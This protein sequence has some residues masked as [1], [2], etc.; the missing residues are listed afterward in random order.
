MENPIHRFQSARRLALALPLAATLALAGGLKA[1]TVTETFDSAESTAAN[2]WTASGNEANGN[3]FGWSNSNEA[4]GTAG[5]AGGFFARSTAYGSY[6]DTSGG[7]LSRTHTLN[8]S[9][10]FRLRNGY[11][12]EG[13][14]YIGF[15]DPASLV[16][17]QAPAN[18]VG[19]SFAEPEADPEDPFL[20]TALVIGNGGSDSGVI[21]LPQDTTLAFNLTWTGS[22]DG[23]GTLTGTLAGTDIGT[24]N[25]AAGSAN[26]T[27]F[28]LLGG[29]N[30]YDLSYLTTEAYF[31]NLT[32]TKV[33]PASYTITYNGN[34]NDG[35]TAPDP[36]TKIENQPLTL[37]SNSGGMAKSGLVFAGWNTAADG[38]GTLYTEGETYSANGDVTLYARWVTAYT[39]T[40]NG[41]NNDSGTAPDPQTKLEIQPLPLAIN[42]GN[43]EKIGVTFAGWNTAA[44]GSGTPYAEGETYTTNANVTL[45]AR[46]GRITAAPGN[47]NDPAT[48]VDG[49]TLGVPQAGSNV[50]LNHAVTLSETT[51]E[52]ESFTNNATLTFNGWNTRLRAATVT[53][54]GTITHPNQTDV[55]GTSGV[56][57]DWTPDHRVWIVCTNLTVNASQSIDVNGKGYQ[58]GQG[59]HPRVGRGSGGGG[60]Y[61]TNTSGGGGTHGGGGGLTGRASIYGS[62]T[63]PGDPGSGGGGNNWGNGGNGGGAVRIE[64]AGKVTLNGSITADGNGP[65]HN[66]AGGGSGGAVF[67]TCNAVAGGGTLSANGAAINGEN[68]QGGAGA[69]G[70]I[71]LAY[72]TAA[73]AVQ[74]ATQTPTLTIR[75]R[76]GGRGQSYS[77]AHGEPGTLH[78]SDASFFPGAA[79]QGGVLH[80]AGVTALTLPSLAISGGMFGVAEGTSLTVQGNV[81]A[82]GRG[83]LYLRNSAIAIGG[84]L[85]LTCGASD[86]G[87]TSIHAG[88]SGSLSVAGNLTTDRVRIYYGELNP[89]V[90]SVTVGGDFVLTNGAPLYVDCAATNETS[91]AYGA[92]IA[93]GGEWRVASGTT[94]SLKSHSTSYS[95]PLFEV[96]SF[97]LEA[98][99]TIN[100][101]RLGSPGIATPTYSNGLGIGRGQG[102]FDAG[103]GGHGGSGGQN[104]SGFGIEYGSSDTPVTAGSSGGTSAWTQSLGGS[105]G[106]CFRL[107]AARD[108]RIDGTVSMDGGDAP[109]ERAGAGSGGGI[110]I[111][112]RAFSGAGTIQAK[113]GSVTLGG[114]T[115]GGGGGGRIA[116]WSQNKDGWVGSLSN[117]VSVAGGTGGTAGATGTLVWGAITP[118][119]NDF[120]A[121]A[122]SQSPPITGGP[123]GD[124]DNDGVKNLI[125]YALADGHE[126]GSFTGSTL[127]F[128]K[129]GAPWGSDITYSIETSEDLGISDPWQAATTTVNNPTTISYTLQNPGDNFARLK[130]SQN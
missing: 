82:T 63:A 54:N 44:D 20:G 37:A 68:G 48:W 12:F 6:A 128:T 109:H 39:I 86:F 70:R 30:S 32:Y 115:G 45:Y 51:P 120:A 73:Q 122:A 83:G 52:L 98:G 80:V 88:A 81:T 77:D 55:A 123:D 99:A 8:M 100:G 94:V 19:I 11:L 47:W 4:G 95:T 121:W 34:N 102:K 46:W 58:G 9:G 57:A 41:N 110:Y 62:L 84:N 117:P 78:L 26:F 127:S 49:D 125:E 31:D 15:F 40:Y 23:S 35:G 75:A 17:G 118:V 61:D 101:N 43:L 53:V 72:D 96:G 24:M 28:G 85:S 25:V 5:E 60:V 27:A 33:A 130:V 38:S 21:N 59:T 129:R 16:S 56:S 2:G 119:T 79:V 3:N 42:Y 65:S 22:P 87:Q 108:V 1:S 76:Q 112:C 7:T 103:G 116:V 126:R 18:F 67:I 10:S 114:K 113:G 97:M 64:A 14:F 93:V 91:P 92:R 111:H 89:A 124:S 90:Q 69:G 105:G 13:K 106:S 29:G 50:I 104:G 107:V 71:A 74:N 36:Q 66:R